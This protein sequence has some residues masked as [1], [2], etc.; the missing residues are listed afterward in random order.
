MG[1]VAG[2]PERAELKT[3]TSAVQVSALTITLSGLPDTSI[4]PTLCGCL[5][6]LCSN[7]PLIQHTESP[8]CPVGEGGMG[9]LVR[10][11]VA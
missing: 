8:A 6:G 10:C 11:I 3:N 9:S 4:P 1:S 2:R 5:K 7:V